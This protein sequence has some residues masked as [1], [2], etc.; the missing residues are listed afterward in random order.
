MITFRIT[1]HFNTAIK[2]QLFRL[3]DIICKLT[4]QLGVG[5]ICA[6]PAGSRNR[7]P[8]PRRQQLPYHITSTAVC[9][10]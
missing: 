4:V 2:E 6:N 5:V 1:V 9:R 8:S 7:P 10:R 3:T